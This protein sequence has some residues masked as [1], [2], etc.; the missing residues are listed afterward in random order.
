MAF[1]ISNTFVPNFWSVNEEGTNNTTVF[2]SL[3][4]AT[5]WCDINGIEYT[6]DTPVA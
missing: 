5:Y 6:I 1:V 2:N 3:D 4:E